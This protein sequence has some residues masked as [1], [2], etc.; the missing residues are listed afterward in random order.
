METTMDAKIEAA[1]KKATTPILSN[2]AAKEEKIEKPEGEIVRLKAQID[3]NSSNSSKPPSQ[4][5]FKKIQNS[6]EKSGQKSGGQP[7]HR[8]SYMELPKNLDEL[9]EKGYYSPTYP[10]PSYYPAIEEQ[11]WNQVH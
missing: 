8:G 4:D 5:G 9:I 1:V 6:R 3:K 7:D 2:L 10:R 11:E